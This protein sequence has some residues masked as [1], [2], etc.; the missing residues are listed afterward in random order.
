MGLACHLCWVAGQD[1]P[2]S[3]TLKDTVR[4]AVRY[5]QLRI[6]AESFGGVS[7]G[8]DLDLDGSQPQSLP[9]SFSSVSVGCPIELYENPVASASPLP[10][11]PGLDVVWEEPGSGS[12]SY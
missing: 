5:S 10:E 1:S 3:L 4:N 9:D 6:L 11:L 7:V 12:D 2:T 8:A